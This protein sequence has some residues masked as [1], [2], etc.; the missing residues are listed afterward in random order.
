[1]TSMVE[2]EWAEDESGRP[3]RGPVGPFES[4]DAARAWAEGAIYN[5]EWNVGHLVSPLVAVDVE[6]RRSDA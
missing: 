4:D 1:M 6:I 3:I 2:I 5:G